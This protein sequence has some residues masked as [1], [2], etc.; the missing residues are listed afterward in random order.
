MDSEFPKLSLVIEHC[1]SRLVIYE[2]SPLILACGK[3][4]QLRQTRRAGVKDGRTWNCGI[5]AV[6][7]ICPRL[8]SGRPENQQDLQLRFSQ[9]SAHGCLHQMPDGSLTGNEPLSRT[10]G[11]LRA[12][13]SDSRRQG[14]GTNPSHRKNAPPK[15]P[16]FSQLEKPF[17]GGQAD[18]L[19]KKIHAPS[20]TRRLMTNCPKISSLFRQ[21]GPHHIR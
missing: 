12:I 13:G 10:A 4:A 2:F 1:H 20:A 8:G 6:G 9:T 18:S 21:I 19:T 14:S 7:E 16:A 5:R 11:T 15:T 3:S 17:R